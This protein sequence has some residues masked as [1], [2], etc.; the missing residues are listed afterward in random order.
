M[1]LKGKQIHF[2]REPVLPDIVA[3]CSFSKKIDAELESNMREIIYLWIENCGGEIHYYELIFDEF[4]DSLYI[5]MD[6]GVVPLEKFVEL[7]A[8]ID[9]IAIKHHANIDRIEIQ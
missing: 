2:L 1:K 8:E 9:G 5:R 4:D 3:V 6:L 7:L